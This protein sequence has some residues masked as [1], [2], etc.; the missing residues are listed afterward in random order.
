MVGPLLHGACM[1]IANQ[2]TPEETISLCRQERVTIL[3]GNPLMF[4]RMLEDPGFDPEAFSSVRLGYFGGS[5]MPLD[6]MRKIHSAFG[7]KH[8]MQTYGMTELGGFMSTTLPEDDIDTACESCGFPFADVEIKLVDIQDGRPDDKGE[9]GMLLT[10]G[11]KLLRYDNLS[12]EENARLFDADGWFITG[13]LMR[14]LEDGR[15]QLVGR[16]KDLIKVGGENVTAAEIEETLSKHP[17]V[18]LTA[19]I[20]VADANR[21]E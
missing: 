12:P 11:Q 1:V 17:E 5:A 19:V 10:R 8:F 2:F 4:K 9:V 13:D 3:S 18:A 7:F 15:L 6:E 21:G 16:L 20:P 14:E